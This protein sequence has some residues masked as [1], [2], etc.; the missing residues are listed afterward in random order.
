MKM[1]FRWYGENDAISLEYI[2]Q[3]PV[4]KGIVSALYDVPV[5]DI[6]PLENI[7]KLKRPAKA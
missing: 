6:W 7:L 1:T 4:I 2:K 3:V 5:G